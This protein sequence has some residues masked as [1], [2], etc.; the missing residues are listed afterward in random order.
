[1]TVIDVT[2]AT[3]MQEVV[4]RSREMPVVV[5]FWAEWC[6]PCRQLG[7]ALERA[8]ADRE[9]K[10]ML[11]KVETDAN[12]NL[13]ASFGIQGI[14]AVKAF[15]G[16][17][18]VDEFVGAQPQ[19]MVD[20]FFDSLLPSEADELVEQ[21]SEEALRSALALEPSRADA[22][23]ALARIMIGRGES[24]DALAVLEPVNG[25]FEADGLA[26]RL[27]LQA[28]GLCSEAFAS[29]DAGD[30]REG[31]QGLLDAIP[32]AGEQRDDVRRAIIGELDGLGAE[33][34]LAR[35]TRRALGAALF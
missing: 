11:A 3:F 21:G 7:P 14:P 4:D 19:P 20:R 25:S 2:E 35:E 28:A 33:D 34:P 23:I 30:T 15:S 10:V 27:R 8:A 24:E 5:D 12:P 9:G 18:I 17:Q 26:A 31:L 22:A 32:T 6:G 13:A 1:M 29:L 16:G